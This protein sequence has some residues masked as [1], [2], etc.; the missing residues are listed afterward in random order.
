MALERRNFASVVAA[1]GMARFASLGIVAEDNEI[2][3]GKD[4]IDAELVADCI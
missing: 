1:V 3:V 2:G 4:M